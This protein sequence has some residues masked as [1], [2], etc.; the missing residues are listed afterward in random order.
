MSFAERNRYDSE[1][2]G[3]SA[4]TAN[5]MTKT[6]DLHGK[7][8]MIAYDVVMNRSQRYIFVAFSV[9]LGLIRCGSALTASE[10]A[11]D[12]SQASSEVPKTPPAPAIAPLKKLTDVVPAERLVDAGGIKTHFVR[13]GIEG[14]QILL[15]HGFGSSTYTWRKNIDRLAEFGRVTAID[16]KGFGLTEKPKDGQY[17]EAAYVRHVLAAMDALGLQKPIIVG[18]SMGGAVAARLALEH[19]E[20]C[21][22]LILVDAA[23]PFTR[24]DFEGAGVDTARFAGR[25]SVF[26]VAMVRSLI[27]RERIRQTLL[28]VYDGHEPVTDEMIDAYYVPTTIEGA[29]QALLAMMNPPAD[30]AKPIPLKNLTCPVTILW[31]KR[32]NVIPVA[33]GEALAREIPNAE[34]VIWAEAGHLPHEDE[35]DRFHELVRDFVRRNSLSGS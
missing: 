9:A 33:A 15:L 23:R 31:G 28:S 4:D 13:K 19:P 10:D 17:G 11:R 25:P 24:L 29:P 21:L 12:R 14:P 2:F 27:T 34:L 22:G 20:R 30:P 18:N 26:A 1:S 3:H 8:T 16:I 5:D 6:Q 7:F 35:P 32:D